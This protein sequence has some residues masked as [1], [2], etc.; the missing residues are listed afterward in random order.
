MADSTIKS[1][2]FLSFSIKEKSTL[3]ASYMP[4]VQNGG[5]FLPTKK[6]FEMGE[7]VFFLLTLM[8][9][10]TKIPIAGSVVW[11]TP[12]ESDTY[13]AGGVGI[14]FNGKDNGVARDKIE[15]YLAGSL[16]SDK[17]THTM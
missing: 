16:S 3:Y 13:K 6:P 10:K 17:P 12:Q 7:E 1:Q 14:Q 15:N 8:E 2:G 4:F 11:I 5:L 9:E